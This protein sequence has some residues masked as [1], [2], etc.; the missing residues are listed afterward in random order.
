MGSFDFF[1]NLPEDR[2]SGFKGAKRGA[3]CQH[4]RGS[5]RRKG[6]V[7]NMQA[8]L[9]TQ[10]NSYCDPFGLSWRQEMRDQCSVNCS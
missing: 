4:F 7:V 3:T 5:R 1:C 2:Q 8:P 10:P 9:F 6:K